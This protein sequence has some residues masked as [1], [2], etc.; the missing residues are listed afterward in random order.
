M[1]LSIIATLGVH[2][3]AAVRPQSAATAVSISATHS[4]APFPSTLPTPTV[5]INCNDPVANNSVYTAENGQNFGVRCN[6]DYYYENAASSQV[7]SYAQC[8]EA[9]S[10]YF[11]CRVFSFMPNVIIGES[12]ESNCFLRTA[13]N[14]NPDIKEGEWSGVKLWFVKTIT[15]TTT[16][17]PTMYKR[18]ATP[19]QVSPAPVAHTL[20]KRRVPKP[21][22]PS[23]MSNFPR[24]T[25]NSTTPMNA[26]T[27]CD[28]PNRPRPTEPDSHCERLKCYGCGTDPNRLGM[29]LPVDFFCRGGGDGKWGGLQDITLQAG[30]TIGLAYWSAP[31]Y[32]VRII[33]KAF[34][35]CKVDFHRA[36][37]GFCNSRFNRA[38]DQKHGGEVS[39]EC[40]LWV[41]D[42][43]PYSAPHGCQPD[44]NNVIQPN[45]CI[46]WYNTE[47]F[48]DE[49]E[50]PSA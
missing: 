47:S 46:Q 20:V 44:P 32:V 49:S 8:A 14:A 31:D 7:L 22:Y 50:C 4:Y 15:S 42:P 16:F 36:A 39:D 37:G 30:Q 26:S 29:R 9:C 41:L 3:A 23:A 18:H 11:G 38:I 28:D 43:Q 10:V 21:R 33:V 48:Y 17:P 2:G 27:T 1:R 45:E 40:S 24:F 12:M 5:T 19:T 13:Q 25:A 6:V 35:N 34:D